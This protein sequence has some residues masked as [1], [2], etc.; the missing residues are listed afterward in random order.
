MRLGNDIVDLTCVE[1]HHP[2]FVT[3]ILNPIELERFAEAHQ[4]PNL[5]WSL[6]A[7]KEAAF[8]AIKQSQAIGFHHQKF[9]VAADLRSIQYQQQTLELRLEQD[10]DLIFALAADASLNQTRSL[11]LRFEHELAPEEQSLKTKELL[12]ELAAQHLG[13][14]PKELAVASQ[15]RIP[16]IQWLDKILPHPASCAHHG[17]FLAASLGITSL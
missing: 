14:N 1:A 12:L 8:K 16:K 10:G 3:R 9:I 11:T 4:N 5:L 17:R 7:A 6:W 15:E 13:L 2:R